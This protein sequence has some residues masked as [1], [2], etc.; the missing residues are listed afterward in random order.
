MVHAQQGENM[1]NSS[2]VAQSSGLSGEQ[3]AYIAGIAHARLV[4]VRQSDYG[5]RYTEWD[6]DAAL[7]LLGY[8]QRHGVRLRLA[9]ERMNSWIGDCGGELAAVAFHK[10]H[11]IYYSMQ[12]GSIARP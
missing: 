9:R 5:T 8:M 3:L 1:T 12:S 7:C 2:K 6:I 10:A 4:V 11:Q